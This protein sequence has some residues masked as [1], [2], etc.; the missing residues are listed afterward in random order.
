[1]LPKLLKLLTDSEKRHA[2]LLLIMITIMT[3]LDVLGVASIM[4][5]LAVLANQEVIQANFYLNYFYVNLGFNSAENFLF[6]LGV[7]VFFLL[8][9]S[10]IFKAFTTYF[11]LHF[12]MRREYS[13]ARKLIHSY[14]SQPYVWY[15][16]QNSS[17][18]GKSI[19]SEVSV[20]V[21]GAVVPALNLIANGFVVLALWLLLLVSKPQLALLVSITLAG[22]Y[23]II[24]KSMGGL[25]DKIGRE[26]LAA[27]ELRYTTVSE[28]FGAIKVLK[29]LGLEKLYLE[30]FSAPA[31][32]MA[33]ASARMMVVTQIPRYALEG[34]AF[35][36]MMLVVLY[37][38]REEQSL[39]SALPIIGLYGL[40]GY[41]MLPAMQ[42]VYASLS[43]LKFT[44]PALEALYGRLAEL[45]PPRML[46]SPER[47]RLRNSISLQN[48]SFG[49]PRTG[50]DSLR[51]VSATI[52]KGERIGVVGETGSGKTT[53]IDVLLGILVPTEGSVIVD[54]VD[55]SDLNRP[56]WQRSIGYVPQ[57][58][59]LSDDSIAR[60]I[61]FGVD[62][63]ELDLEEIEK[64]AKAAKIHDFIVSQ[65][66]DGYHSKVGERGVRLS[67]GQKQRIGIA[68]ALYRKPDLLVFDEATSA[69]DTVTEQLVMEALASLDKN[70][71]VV[72]IAHRLSTV[73]GCDQIWM[74]SDGQLSEQ[75]TYKSL[76][77][78]SE[79]FRRLIESRKA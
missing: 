63:S 43:Q 14:L 21:N 37:L 54:S 39:E 41:R 67:G 1:M 52:K 9:L 50:R 49:Y 72:M 25:L 55:I 2:L 57:E 74:L 77:V 13:L 24:F 32:S 59:F 64:C 29:F 31:M 8:V 28:A 16:H 7:V 60:N 78:E 62:Q 76:L 38:M 56:N 33:N 12:A 15:L 79:S 23:V 22:S 47:L 48:M 66:E 42:H 19:L 27:N 58:I 35:G 71:T 46:G 36:G 17:E 26:R 20:V 3:F 6:A 53:L 68:R 34:V 5:F 40:A 61:A 4:P 69:L 73:E 65:L 30:R 70:I 11:Q 18:L 51:G 45:P 75:G 10:L 44:R